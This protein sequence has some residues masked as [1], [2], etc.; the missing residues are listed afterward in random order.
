MKTIKV[1]KHRIKKG[2]VILCLAKEDVLG[3][4][5]FVDQNI[6]KHVQLEELRV[7]ING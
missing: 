1:Y 7:L 2:R 5:E 6:P 3:L 4:I